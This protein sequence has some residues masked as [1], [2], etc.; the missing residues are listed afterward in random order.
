MRFLIVGAGFTGSVIAREL[1]N[2]GHDITIIDQRNH[3][4][5]NCFTERDAKTN[6]IEHVYGPHIFHTDNERV[7]RYL[8]QYGKIYS[9]T[10]RVKTVYKGNVY[11]LPINLHTINQFYNRKL[12]PHEAKEFIGEIADSSINTPENFEEQALKFI[13]KDLYEAFF[14]GYTVKQ[15]GI[16]PKELPASILKRLPVRF[17]Y[18]DNYFSH[19]YQGIPEKGYTEIV[20]KIISHDNIN[21]KLSTSFNKLMLSDFDHVI[22]TGKLDEWFD[23]SEGKLSYRTLRFE[24]NYAE[25]DFQGTAVMNYGDKEVPYTRISE[26][27]HF[28]PWENHEGTIFFKEY[29]SVCGDSDI[30]YYPIRLVN[31]KELLSKYFS[32]TDNINGV[33]FAGRLGS[34]RY[35]DMDVTINEAL[36]LSDEL[37]K[38]ISNGNSPKVFYHKEKL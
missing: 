7:W 22:W 10:N 1:A 29:S 37:I 2:A 38:D 36:E 11:S 31:D 25:G 33:T 30:P 4:A 17:N 8:N 20:E 15:W 9:Y 21:I 19:K 26:H 34:Y 23:Y 16:D 5:G 6:I 32:L 3:I 18:D 28:T 13:G 12:S 27:K 35:M 24:K 14:K